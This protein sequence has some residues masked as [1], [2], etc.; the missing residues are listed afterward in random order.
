ML[1]IFLNFTIVDNSRQPGITN[2]Y[3][4]IDLESES[5]SETELTRGGENA[6]N[7]LKSK[8]GMTLTELIS[9]IIVL[10]LVAGILT[11]GVRLGAKAYVESVSASEA[12]VLCATLTETIADELRYAYSVAGDG[13]TETT[14]VMISSQK[15]G[16]SAQTGSDDAVLK[17]TTDAHGHIYLQDTSTNTTPS[18]GASSST[19]TSG[20][21]TD[22][23]TAEQEP[24]NLILSTAAYPYNL[25][26]YVKDLTYDSA[27]RIFSLTIEVQGSSG[28]TLATTSFEVRKVNP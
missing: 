18:T 15:F 2:T 22:T 1:S 7:K 23:S 10:L 3:R 17:F 26:A 12:Q 13:K 9:G 4:Y 28:N 6:M 8:S 19:G 14:P 24:E 21:G 5:E 25:H 16:G 20:T 11:V 27:S